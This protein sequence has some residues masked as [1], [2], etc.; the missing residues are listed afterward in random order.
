MRLFSSVCAVGLIVV[1]IAG[2]VMSARAVETPIYHSTIA[3]EV[4][5]MPLDEK[6]ILTQTLTPQNTI[7]TASITPA[8]I[9]IGSQLTVN[10]SASGSFNATNIFTAQISDPDGNFSAPIAIGTVSGTSSGSILATIPVVM[11][12]GTKYRIR[13]VSSGPSI[14]G[15]DNGANLTLHPL[16]IMYSMVGNGY[17]CVGD[18]GTALGLNSTEP[19]IT[20][21]LL[22]NG[23]PVGTPINGNNLPQNF[24]LQKAE[25]V[26]KVIGTNSVSGCSQ[27]M[28]DSIVLTV[29]PLPAVYTITG[30]GAYC[31]DQAGA[32][33]GLGNSQQGVQYELIL[34]SI[35]TGKF[36][37]GTGNPITFGPQ[38]DV[39]FY[40]IIA[41]NII[42]GC[43][44][45]MFG[46][47][48]VSINPIPAKFTMLGGG[49][50]CEGDPGVQMAL[51]SSEPNT[52][53]QLKLNGAPTGTPKTGTGAPVEFGFQTKQ[54]TYS[55]E[56]TNL[57]TGCTA[58]MIGSKSVI[59]NPL[60]PK[61]SITKTDT[62]LKSSAETGNIWYRNLIEIPNVNAQSYTPTQSG[63]Y[64]VAVKL[65]GCMSAMSEAVT[66]TLAGEKLQ[67]A[68]TT[69]AQSGV[70][71]LTVQFIDSSRGNPTSWSWDFGDS[72]H[73]SE[74]NPV[75]S[76]T[77]PGNYTVS[78]VVA[79]GL[80]SDSISRANYI[81]VTESS[82][83][84]AEFTATTQFGRVPLRIQ[85]VDMSSGTPTQWKWDF[86]DGS[87]PSEESNP[88]HTYTVAG[89][90]SDT[91][92]ITKNSQT[93]TITKKDFITI[94]SVTGVQEHEV[95][96]GQSTLVIP[97]PINGKN[98]R[99]RYYS[100]SPQI[101]TLEL[102]TVLGQQLQSQQA[103]VRNGEN[104]MHV[105]MQ[106][107]LPSGLYFLKIHHEDGVEVHVVKIVQ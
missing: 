61:P 26:Y 75:H 30:G 42:T 98:F 95:R 14:D 46:G 19:G 47:M 7:T 65:K 58:T 43:T 11:N 76:Y 68:F 66:V 44:A 82:V 64:T 103:A 89:K 31:Q 91:L 13:V 23:T 37:N 94:D 52:S 92:T 63:S 33:I 79:D 25:G 6:G 10:F 27:L 38:S 29:N 107:S 96:T 21:R 97:N 48:R 71:P 36:V 100:N 102:F 99:V 18:S 101:L 77:K 60:P 54:G 20:Y 78:L 55:V 57:T 72:Q 45:T 32:V 40:T 67:A 74:Q 12:E 105:E 35:A 85:F 17:T 87:N 8:S 3:R 80:Q 22:R 4:L 53:Y 5:P 2:A 83:L 104:T 28:N 86:G 24:G 88:L 70:A 62:I 50:Y 73:S 41:R 51:Y 39:G 93:S 16:P 69:K 56:A 81:T 34:N 49:T 1:L 9:C 84:T 15:S 90:Y 106:N 59:M